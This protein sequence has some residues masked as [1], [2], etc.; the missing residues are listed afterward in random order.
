[1]EKKSKRGIIIILI[2]L[3]IVIALLLV[4]CPRVSPTSPATV[5]TPKS[6]VSTESALPGTPTPA[7]ETVAEVLSPATVQGP[8][9]VVAGA[10]FSLAWTGPNNPGDFVTVA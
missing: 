6:A 1:M 5:S 2:A 10:A 3:L 7:A 4:R 8:A 9:D